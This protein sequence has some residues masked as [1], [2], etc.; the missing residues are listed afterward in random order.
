MI[1][2]NDDGENINFSNLLRNKFKR[3]SID[4]KRFRFRIDF[5]VKDLKSLARECQD[6]PYNIRNSLSDQLSRI[7]FYIIGPKKN[8]SMVDRNTVPL[9][10]HD[11]M[12]SIAGDG[13]RNTHRHRTV[14]L[15]RIRHDPQHNQRKRTQKTPPHDDDDNERTLHKRFTKSRE[16]EREPWSTSKRVKCETLWRE[17]REKRLKGSGSGIIIGARL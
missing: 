15:H 2:W 10:R 5:E 11:K 16:E 7:L 6:F 1:W 9:N 4:K 12:F 3:V 8:Q 14:F 13:V 17:G